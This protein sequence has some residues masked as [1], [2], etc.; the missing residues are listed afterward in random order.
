MQGGGFIQELLEALSG[1]FGS[2]SLQL[3][4]LVPSPHAELATFFT[5]GLRGTGGTTPVCSLSTILGHL[6][7]ICVPSHLLICDACKQVLD[8]V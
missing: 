7:F 5:P 1:A 6:Q 4:D 2:D 8:L 3:E